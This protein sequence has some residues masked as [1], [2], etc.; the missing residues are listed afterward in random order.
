MA[1]DSK[2]KPP[3]PKRVYLHDDDGSVYPIEIPRE[4]E[5]TVILYLGKP[6]VHK[7]VGT[8]ISDDAVFQVRPFL[9]VE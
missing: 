6:F 2:P 4:A 8:V 5:P 9:I 3:P 7:L 1:K